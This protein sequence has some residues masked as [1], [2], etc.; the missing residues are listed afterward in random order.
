[1]PA[2]VDLSDDEDSDDDEVSDQGGPVPI[3]RKPLERARRIVTDESTGPFS[4]DSPYADSRRGC[5]HGTRRVR[6][7]ALSWHR[8]LFRYTA[9][10]GTEN[11]DHGN[12][13]V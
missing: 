9:D 12:R 8:T 1:M 7:F 10:T 3:G 5:A 13:A 4:C 2:L 6:G 11:L